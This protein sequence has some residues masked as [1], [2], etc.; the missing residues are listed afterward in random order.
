VPTFLHALSFVA[1]F[2]VLFVL[3]GASVG[4]LGEILYERLPLLRQLG[5]LILIIFGLHVAGIITIPLLYREKKLTIEHNPRLGY[6]S[7]FIIGATFSAGWTPCV[8]TILGSIL[9]LAS[10]TATAMQG[11]VMLSAYSLGLGVPFL[12]AGLA[13]GSASGILRRLN[14]HLNVV[15]RISGIM[16]IL[17]GIAIWFDLLT[18][19]TNLFYWTP[20]GV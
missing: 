9:V 19:F 6:L 10:T 16:L 5:A 11:A 17:M 3:L 18:R 8:G 7:S 20:G 15:S 2:S 1:G 13:I 12:V 14:R 4:S